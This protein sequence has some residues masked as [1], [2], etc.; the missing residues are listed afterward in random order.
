MAWDMGYEPCCRMRAAGC[1]K[2]RVR[3]VRVRKGSAARME[4]AA[5][6]GREN[7]GKLNRSWFMASPSRLALKSS[8]QTQSAGV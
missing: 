2:V 7:R 3:T 5:R 8:S 1:P 6:K 4:E